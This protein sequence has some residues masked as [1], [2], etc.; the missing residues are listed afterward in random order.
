MH[1]ILFYKLGVLLNDPYN[2]ILSHVTVIHSSGLTASLLTIQAWNY[3]LFSSMMPS[4]DFYFHCSQAQVIKHQIGF[5]WHHFIYIL[6]VQV[7]WVHKQL[8]RTPLLFICKA[9]VLNLN[10]FFKKTPWS[11]ILL[12]AFMLT[13]YKSRQ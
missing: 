3:L 8:P 13:R 10:Y 4:G 6:T 11:Q 7:I 9:I 1:W 12:G 5:H 2:K